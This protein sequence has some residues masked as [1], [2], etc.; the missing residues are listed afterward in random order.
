MLS[1]LVVPGERIAPIEVAQL[2]YNVFEHDGKIISCVVGKPVFDREARK[3]SVEAVKELLIP[4]PGDRIKGRVT[5]VQDTFA[6]VEI[7]VIGKKISR[8]NFIGLLYI[9]RVARRRIRKMTE[10]LKAGD[11]I[12]AEVVAVNNGAVYLSTADSSDGVFL[13]Y[14]SRCGDVLK[15]VSKNKLACQ[16]CGAR[17]SR[18]ISS[19][20]GRFE[21]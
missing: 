17:E 9:S 11:L 14:C 20:Y 12:S 6:V 4:R 1:D 10:V 2:G 7:L 18:K 5:K 3:L 16:S 15:Y 19:E 8:S 21:V 13:G